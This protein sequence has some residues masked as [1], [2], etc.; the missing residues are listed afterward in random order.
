MQQHEIPTEKYDLFFQRAEIYDRSGLVEWTNMS[1]YDNEDTVNLYDTCSEAKKLSTFNSPIEIEFLDFI[2]YANISSVLDLGC[3]AGAFYHLLKSV[4]PNVAYFG[5][6]ISE[7]QIRRARSRFSENF[8][9]RDVSRISL[10]ELAKFDAV[11]EYSVFAFL[12]PASQVDLIRK[13]LQSG[14]KAL[15]E[16]NVTMP[17]IDFAPRSCFKDFTGQIGDGRTLFTTVSFPFKSE[18]E[19]AVQGTG[20]IVEFSQSSYGATRALNKLERA[21]GALGDK[22]LIKCRQKEFEANYVW[23]RTWHIL[24]A[25]IIPLDWKKNSQYDYSSIPKEEI[26]PMLR[27]RLK[28]I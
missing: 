16:I 27:R 6:D 1:M 13:V 7:S 10:D 11:H 8:A 5:Y 14:A 23:P 22:K 26:Q 17:H 18:I 25:K 12:S 9:V 24:R 19:A 3:G 28:Q 4:H 2:E 20:H 21:G 15:F